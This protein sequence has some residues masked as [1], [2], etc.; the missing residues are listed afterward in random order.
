M[1]VAVERDGLVAITDKHL[2]STISPFS[3]LQLYLKFVA[4]AVV[5]VGLK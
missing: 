4:N 1:V 3:P 5:T 2:R